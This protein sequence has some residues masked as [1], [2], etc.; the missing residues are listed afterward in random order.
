MRDRTIIFKLV[1]LRRNFV[2]SQTLPER[3][4]GCSLRFTSADYHQE[5]TELLTASDRIAAD[6]QPLYA[7]RDFTKL[8]TQQAGKCEMG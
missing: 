4:T 8:R 7:G 2:R 3:G 5:V 6:Y 1:G